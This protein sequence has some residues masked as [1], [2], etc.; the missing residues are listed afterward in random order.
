MSMAL[1]DA[2]AQERVEARDGFGGVKGGGAQRHAMRRERGLRGLGNR[3]LRERV[4]QGFKRRLVFERQMDALVGFDE[5][6]N[7]CG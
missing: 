3:L 1:K 7:F 5:N 2:D 4:R 6:E